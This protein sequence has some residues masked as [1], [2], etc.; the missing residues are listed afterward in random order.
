MDFTTNKILLGA[1]G[2]AAPETYYYTYINSFYNSEG[3]SGPPAVDDDGNVFFGWKSKS[4][5]PYHIYDAH[6]IVQLDEEG[7][8]V[9]LIKHYMTPSS[10]AA[11]R[12][13]VVKSNGQVVSSVRGANRYGIASINFATPSVVSAA[14][15]GGVYSQVYIEPFRV[16][17]YGSSDVYLLGRWTNGSQRGPNIVKL[18]SSNQLQWSRFLYTSY[19]YIHTSDQGNN[20]DI[21]ICTTNNG[22][23]TVVVVAKINTSGSFVTGSYINYVNGSNLFEVALDGNGDMFVLTRATEQVYN[24]SAYW[25]NGILAKF[26]GSTGALIWMKEIRKYNTSMNYNSKIAVGDDGV[27]HLITLTGINGSSVEYMYYRINS[28]GTNIYERK[29]SHTIQGYTGYNP[30]LIAKNKCI[31]ITM[32]TSGQGQSYSS[33]HNLIIKLPDSG[34]ITGT[35]NQLSITNVGTFY[36]VQNLG[37]NY[38]TT[39]FGASSAYSFGDFT[40]QTT[41][42][43]TFHTNHNAQDNNV[44]DL[45]GP[46]FTNY[47]LPL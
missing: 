34:D 14:Y 1:S 38:S 43:S 31:Y 7:N 3:I 9:D 37:S 25:N 46:N 30:T 5:Y 8:K 10:G 15:P 11:G 47:T 21:A 33:H 18:N 45:T 23:G 42:Y 19:G 41:M 24:P 6:D 35:Y 17:T 13:V 40:S 32:D 22:S 44:V 2:G 29:I 12:G 20:G 27:L 4:T 16:Y 26:N 36:T 39:P 28:S